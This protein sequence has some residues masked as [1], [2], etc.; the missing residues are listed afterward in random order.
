[1]AEGKGGFGWYTSFF[2][3]REASNLSR[4]LNRRLLHE[5][6]DGLPAFP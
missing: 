4:E 1:V 5:D 6:P 3:L 2:V